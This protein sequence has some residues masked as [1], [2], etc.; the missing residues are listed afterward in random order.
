MIEILLSLRLISDS[1]AFQTFD[2]IRLG[3][4]PGETG[5]EKFLVILVLPFGIVVL[6]TT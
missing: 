1:G 3:L 4:D 6:L 5:S 2:S